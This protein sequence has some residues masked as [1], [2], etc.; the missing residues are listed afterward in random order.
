VKYFTNRGMLLPLPDTNALAYSAGN[1]EEKKFYNFD[2][3]FS[4]LPSNLIA[5]SAATSGNQTHPVRLRKTTGKL[6]W[7]S[8]Q[9]GLVFFLLIIPSMDL[10]SAALV[11]Q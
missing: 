10:T 1:D 9:L 5:T 3:S 8:H 7:Y 2:I 11:T 6:G 4:L